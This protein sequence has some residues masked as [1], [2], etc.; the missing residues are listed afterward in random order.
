[1]EAARLVDM[2]CSPMPVAAAADRLAPRLTKLA[3]KDW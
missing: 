3:A 2:P 1:M